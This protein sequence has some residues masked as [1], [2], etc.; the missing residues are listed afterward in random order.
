[1]LLG[2]RYL[3]TV[4]VADSSSAGPTIDLM[5]VALVSTFHFLGRVGHFWAI[6]CFMPPATP[7]SLSIIASTWPRSRSASVIVYNIVMSTRV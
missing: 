4:E 5:R 3:D 6:H 2:G 1:M 7:V